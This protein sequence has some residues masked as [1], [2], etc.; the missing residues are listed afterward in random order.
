M[1]VLEGVM[2]RYDFASH[3]EVTVAAPPARTVEALMSLDTSGLLLT[4]LLMGM[5]S[6]PARIR[7]REPAAGR[8]RRGSPM[9]DA[10]IELER[11]DHSA[12]YG[13]AGQFWKPVARPVKLDG[14]AAFAAFD[15]PGNAKAVI[16][17]EVRAAPGGSV[18]AT[19]TRIAATDENARRVFGRYWLV[20]RAGSGLIRH[21]MLRAVRRSAEDG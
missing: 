12:A 4:R 7:S 13:I 14:P 11:N 19:E 2:P 20:V 18:L 5:R 15:E 8:T 3:H 17:F 21:D 6:I 9:P 10:F 16:G 1:D